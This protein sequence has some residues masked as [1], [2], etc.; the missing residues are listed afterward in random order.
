MAVT[1]VVSAAEHAIG[2]DWDE[3]G[4]V[5]AVVDRDMKVKATIRVPATVVGLRDVV[6]LGTAWLNP[7]GAFPPI[8]VEA[9]RRP[10]LPALAAAGFDVYVTNANA[11]AAYRKQF[12]HS[13][14]SKSDKVDAAMLGHRLLL[15]PESH[16]PLPPLSSESLTLG[17]LTRLQKD[18][19]SMCVDQANRL[20]S[21]L[22]EANP[23]VLD[24]WSTA[25]LCD[26]PMPATYL[27]S[28]P[29]AW[30]GFNL[31][32][33]DL[34]ERIVKAGRGTKARMLAKNLHD[35]YQTDYIKY[36]PSVNDAFG[37]VIAENA[38][39]LERLLTS[40]REVEDA[41][42]AALA[43]H[44][45]GPL[46]A[47]ARGAG[48]SVLSRVIAEIGDDPAR[49]QTLRGFLAYAAVVP[50]TAQSGSQ[51]RDSRRPTKGNRLHSALWDW[52]KGASNHHPGA[53]TLYWQRREAGDYHPTA[54]RKLAACI[55]ASIWH[56][57]HT[58][59]VWDDDKVWPQPR[60]DLEEYKT[61]VRADVK[62]RKSN[63]AVNHGIKPGR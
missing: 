41:I 61:K 58:G 10:L 3:N 48:P 24:V 59:E 19:V 44:P 60:P 25:Q 2:Y 28:T 31:G 55:A 57:M 30:E 38:A 18:L 29:G 37:L 34:H 6:A 45:M 32:Q 27:T 40:R 13:G 62:A 50:Y 1:D 17:A 51:Q 8:V 12:N 39:I 52:A 46:L 35:A 11:L 4:G 16:R 15:F 22:A 56:C 20:R 33:P 63:K 5:F 47:P 21:V 42:A 36:P 43:S 23:A 7:A 54:T 14:R 9:T 49:F 53:A 26:G